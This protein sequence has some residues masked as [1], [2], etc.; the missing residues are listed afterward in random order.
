MSDQIPFGTEDFAQNPEPRCPCLLLLDV[1]GSMQGDPISELNQ[2]L[3]TFRDELVGDSLSAKRVE[4]A[5]VTFGPVE[6]LHDFVGAATYQPIELTPK[7]DTPMGAAIEQALQMVA[8]RK[9]VYKQAGISFYRPWVFM[10]TDG[11][12]TDSWKEAAR[13]IHDGEQRK[14][15]AFFAVGVKGA[16]FEILRQISVR[17][18]LMLSGLR[19]KDLFVWLSNSMKSVSR[20]SPGADVPIPNPTVPGGWASV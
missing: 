9:D 16:N 15:F 1:S 7:A 19:F 14:S 6:V 18:P 8:Q 2:G 3:Q 5:T 11:G 17:E 12:P 20:S 13:L 4:V 10:I